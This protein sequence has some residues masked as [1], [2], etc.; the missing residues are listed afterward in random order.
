MNSKETTIGMEL[1]LIRTARGESLNK[2]AN[3][4][5]IGE[6]YLSEL[7]RMK[8]NPSDDVVYSIA[9]YYNL[10]EKYLFDRYERIPLTVQGEILKSNVLSDTLYNIAMNKSITTEE[11]AELYDKIKGIYKLFLKNDPPD[12]KDTPQFGVSFF[13]AFVMVY[14]QHVGCNLTVHSVLDHS[15]L[16]R[17]EGCITF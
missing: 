5:G 4:I 7:E 3:G 6:S 14:P 16:L 10:D 13:I 12:K 1:R 11:K 2:A 9:K 8:R 15:H 17:M